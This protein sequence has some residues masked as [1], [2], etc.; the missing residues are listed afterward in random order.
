MR[1]WKYLL[2]SRVKSRRLGVG[3][4]LSVPKTAI[5]CT[6]PWDPEMNMTALP[7]EEL[8]TEVNATR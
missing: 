4:Q 5:L 6:W 2:N 8:K 1:M 3:G 7:L